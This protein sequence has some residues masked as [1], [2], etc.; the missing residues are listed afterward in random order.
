[1]Y[2]ISKLARRLVFERGYVPA[3]IVLGSQWGDEGKG[4][5][6]DVF[7]A[8]A[9]Y[10]VRYQGGANAGH[11][12]KIKDFELILHLIPSGILQD[13]T[14]CV[15][16][17]GLVLDVETLVKEIKGLKKLGFLKQDSRLRISDSACLLLNYHKRLD[18][19]R[20]AKAGHDKI[21]TTGKGIGPAYESRA[22]RKALLFSDL[23]L[24]KASLREKLLK[25]TKEQ[26]F[27]LEKFYHQARI[28]VDQVLNDLTQFAEFLRPYRCRDTSW[29]I[30]QALENNKKVLLEGAQGSLL[31]L[32]HG[33]YPY[34]TSSST[35]AGGALTGVGLGFQHI[36]KVVAITKAYTTRVGAG[37]FPTE[38]SES[39]AGLHLQTKGMELGAT[40]G[41]KRRTGWLDI[42][43]LKY[44]KRLNGITQLALMKLDVLSGLDEIKVCV[45]YE[46]DGK[47]IDHF[48]ALA[49]DLEKIKPKYITLKSWSEDITSVR[50]FQELPIECQDYCNFISRETGLSIDM[51]SVGPCREQTLWLSELF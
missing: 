22:E 18:Q 10:V 44:A 46:Q 13:D 31:D 36:S 40:T 8:D 6:V 16:S 45:S 15:I 5:I 17:S 4:K 14:C 48:P 37:P 19:A 26:D 34:V 42:P 2:F 51:I 39:E 49:S 41:R 20:E 27:L 11:T 12:L 25:N 33:T 35:V 3:A 7:S 47:P 24:D 9:D 21:G 30:H 23:F 29:L 38:C 1:M 50:K 28:D 32:V 43:A